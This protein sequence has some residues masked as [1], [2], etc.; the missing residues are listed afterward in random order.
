MNPCINSLVFI[1]R[2]PMLLK[3]L[4]SAMLQVSNTN[5]KS[6]YELLRK[7]GYNDKDATL[8]ADK[9]DYI[10]DVDK[11]V[12][13]KLDI[14]YF[15]AETISAWVPNLLPIVT[16]LR[17]KYNDSIR[18]V[19]QSTEEGNSIYNTND[20]SGLFFPD[21]FKVDFCCNGAYETE[22]FESWSSLI[23][24][25]G[26]HFEKANINPYYTMEEIREAVDEAYD[27]GDSEY[28]FNIN[29]YTP[30]DNSN[31]Y[32]CEYSLEVA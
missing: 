21:K 4:H 24:Y 18:L 22:F 31:F 26:N 2:N 15:S 10:S 7:H 9:R 14:F 19:A 20:I 1:S 28:F 25:L 30:Y 17:E 6:I 23:D 16:M 29:V 8:L 12:T 11:V 5:S 27:D 13:A 32:S 3:R